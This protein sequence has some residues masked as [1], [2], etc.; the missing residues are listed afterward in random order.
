MLH[1][2]V[3]QET[4][5][6]PSLPLGHAQTIA[7]AYTKQITDEAGKPASTTFHKTVEVVS[8]GQTEG[9]NKYCITCLEAHFSDVRQPD[10]SRKLQLLLLEVFDLLVV[11]TDKTGKLIQ[12]H[13]FDYLQETWQTL[14]I[15]IIQDHDD[16]AYLKR[17]SDMDALMQSYEGVMQY[18]SLPSNYGL[19]FNGYKNFNLAE[20]LQFTS[21]VYG[22]ELSNRTVEEQINIQV[23]QTQ[24]LVTFQITEST[25]Q[26]HSSYIGS[27]IYLDGVL[28]ACSKEIKTESFTI[29][30]SA[31]WVGLKKSFLQ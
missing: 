18:L 5:H 21:A 17:I 29:N 20:P 25:Q 28:D 2:S 1:Q 19:Y 11:S 24:Q 31:K 27:C 14:R 30:Y 12:I 9:R 3:S 15:E 23:T 26:N 22:E 7:F 6:L 4:K 13:N 16:E 10:P 8:L